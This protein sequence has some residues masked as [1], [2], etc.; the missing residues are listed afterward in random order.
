MR[1]VQLNEGIAAMIAVAFLV[2]G[3]FVVLQPFV[4]DLLWAVVLSFSTWPLYSRAVDI[5]GGRRTA[6]ATLMTSLLATTLVAP[7]L[8]VGFSL[9][10]NVDTLTVAIRKLLEGPPEPPA[11]LN[12]VPFVGVRL[13]DYWQSLAQDGAKFLAELQKLFAAMSKW[14][15]DTGLVLGAGIFKLALSVFITFFLYRDGAAIAV[16]L[17]A[18]MERIAG[19]RAQRLL[20]LA[21]ATVRGVVYGIL[22]TALAQ[23]ILAGLG[24]WIAGVPGPFFLGLL[25][26]FLSVI[27]MGPPLVW[28]PASLWLFNQG[29]TGWG[30]FLV[31]WGAIVVSSID[32]IIKPYLI[33]QGSDLP[34]VLV[35][36][37]VL[38]GA[39]AFGLI[40]IFLG[41]TLLAV[42]YNLFREWTMSGAAGPAPGPDAS[43]SR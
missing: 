10:E 27:P 16:R 11:W 12:D 1:M 30:I 43:P 8:V 42:G 19:A 3:C 5:L 22:G 18:G 24:F 39:I 41:P 23:G 35:L 17:R 9:G 13:Q 28:L 2:V 15:L 38:G 34:F 31:V 14:L 4:S 37:G 6:A 25:S 29:S 36:L 20:E 7:F 32:N 40:G 33:S 21:G 26:F